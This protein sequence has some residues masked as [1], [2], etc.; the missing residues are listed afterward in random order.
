MPGTLTFVAPGLPVGEGEIPL[1]RLER[2]LLTLTTPELTPEDLA[3]VRRRSHEITDAVGSTLPA[4]LYS[5]DLHVP[6][7]WSAFREAFRTYSAAPQAA[8]ELLA[9]EA[10]KASEPERI[11]VREQVNRDWYSFQGTIL[12]A[13]QQAQQELGGKA[14]IV[15]RPGWGMRAMREQAIAQALASA[16][17]FPLSARPPRGQA[18]PSPAETGGVLCLTLGPTTATLAAKLREGLSASHGI[19]ATPLVSE[20]VAV[21]VARPHAVE[22]LGLPLPL[23]CKLRPVLAGLRWN[24]RASRRSLQDAIGRH[25]AHAMVNRTSLALARELPGVALILSYAEQLMEYLRPSAIVS[26]HLYGHT[27]APF[28]LE[29]RARG[30]PVIYVQH[31]VYLAKDR[32]LEPLE[33]DLSCVFGPASA[34]M[35]AGRPGETVI[36]GQPGGDEGRILRPSAAQP[37]S[38]S[39][40]P[41]GVVPSDGSAT[42][43]VATQPLRP[44]DGDGGQ[45]DQWLQ[46]VVEAAEALGA[47]VVIKPHPAETDLAEYEALAQR[48]PDCVRLLS[49][50]AAT[51]AELLQT[52][53]VLVTMDSTVVFDAAMAGVPAVTINL[54]GRR[55]RFPFAQDGGAV[56]VYRYEDIQPTLTRLLREPA[57]REELAATREAFLDRHIGC[58]DGNAIER[59]AE[60]IAQLVTGAEARRGNPQ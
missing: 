22:D 59:I 54:T 24:R 30:I 47:Q 19:I 15:A 46:G 8:N 43:L 28:V 11:V 55:D 45:A 3:W 58:R 9:R 26:F 5:P 25:A 17:S 6:C 38:Y 42:I 37:G 18:M 2:D 44:E 4:R 7:F 10:L 12:E 33:Y 53:A 14:E 51:I 57:A 41:D 31:G 39:A 32:C 27:L 29:A 50:D 52:S 40:P 34:E 36:V 56:G 48:H 60:H 13:V 23:V 21:A 35:F 49:A 1:V 20:A 16:G